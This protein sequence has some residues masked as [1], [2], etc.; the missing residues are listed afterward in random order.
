MSEY[1]NRDEVLAILHGEIDNDAIEHL[2]SK[3]EEDFFNEFRKEE[4]ILER[5]PWVEQ[6]I[7]M[8]KMLVDYKDRVEGIGMEGAY[9]TDIYC[10]KNEEVNVINDEIARIGRRLGKFFVEEVCGST[11]E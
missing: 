4:G 10:G 3:T 11:K 2:P 9:E 6:D 8:R 1:I 5:P 7:L